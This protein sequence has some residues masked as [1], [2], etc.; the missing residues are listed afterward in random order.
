MTLR[1]AALQLAAALVGSVGFSILFH[2]RGVKLAMAGLGGLLTWG[3]YLLLRE[4]V[5][6]LLAANLLAAC[7]ASA[8][9]EVMARVLRAPA[10]VFVT[11]AVIS[12]V[13]GGALYNT[14]YC[15][16]TGDAAGA[17][18]YGYETWNVAVGVAVGI[19][20]TTS[21]CTFLTTLRRRAGR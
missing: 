13:P 10:T 19:A 18:A 5:P 3:S 15:A 16:V 20:V 12:L 17:S 9:A 6:S 4:A 14:M 1:D 8:Y 7:L 2:I 21:V 11:P